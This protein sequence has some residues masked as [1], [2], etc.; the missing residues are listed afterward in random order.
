[1]NWQF[2][3]P[4]DPAEDPLDSIIDEIWE[5]DELLLDAIH[6]AGNNQTIEMA[7]GRHAIRLLE[8]RRQNQ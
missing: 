2:L 4:A 8:E 5:N 1:M 7:V 6:A 3:H